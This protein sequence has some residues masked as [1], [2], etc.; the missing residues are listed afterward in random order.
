VLNPKEEHKLRRLEAKVSWL[1][2]P[3]CRQH[4]TVWGLCVPCARTC[5]KVGH[6]NNTSCFQQHKFCQ[7]CGWQHTH[8]LIP[9]NKAKLH[10]TGRHYKVHDWTIH[11]DVVND[12]EAKDAIACVTFEMNFGYGHVAKFTCS[13][14]KRINEGSDRWRFQFSQQVCASGKWSFQSRQQTHA[15]IH[16]S[17]K[18]MGVGGI[19]LLLDCTV[20]DNSRH[21]DSLL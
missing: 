20:H 18:I 8:S 13:H 16:I 7:V 17:I 10:W 4:K 21:R 3:P 11:L 9:R 5:N 14:P 1:K 12:D 19:S 2:P 15:F 6:N